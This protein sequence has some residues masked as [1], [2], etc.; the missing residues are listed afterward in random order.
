MKLQD[1]EI[2]ML[3][4]KSGDCI[5]IT[6]L[7]ENYRIL[8]DG[9]YSDTYDKYL[10]PF[11]EQL[12]RKGEKLNLIIATHIDRDHISGIKRF[13][14]ENGRA[15]NPQIIQVD[16]IWF[17]GFRNI[18]LPREKP[19]DI[20]FALSGL[21][22]N[23]AAENLENTESGSEDISFHD[24]NCLADIIVQNDYLWNGVFKNAVAADDQ[25]VVEHGNIRIHILNPLM[26]D[27][28]ELAEAWIEKL[29]ENYR[30]KIIITDNHLFDRAFEG[31]YL[32]EQ[33]HEGYDENISYH[34]SE[35]IDW[36]AEAE[37]ENARPDNSLQNRSSIAI[38]IE[39][40]EVKMLFPGDC[41]LYKISD[42][43]PDS[44]TVVKLPHHGSGKSNMKEFIRERTVKYYLVSTDGSYGHPSKMIVGNILCH[45][46]GKPLIVTNYPLPGFDKICLVEGGSD[47]E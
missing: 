13:L 26:E 2:K 45:A 46:K 6:F 18:S 30:G 20:P 3:P 4:A 38:L 16:D 28:N 40:G 24:G 32:Y 10:K 41:P 27:L 21:L 25:A 36:E 37:K 8:I 19:Y 43:V 34:I 42:K 5:L 15:D 29:K 11:L 31:C 9:G 7:K 12:G 35:K 1:I 14:A 39:Y 23:M 33:P 47:D 22:Q 44:I 17:N